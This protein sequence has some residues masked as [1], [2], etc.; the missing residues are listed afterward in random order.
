MKKSE[1]KDLI[2]ECIEEIQTGETTIQD[3]NDLVRSMYNDLN[4]L[5]EKMKKIG[6]VVSKE[7][8][9]STIRKSLIKLGKRIGT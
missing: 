2:R 7:K 3:A 1:L 6:I 5:S 9:I 8:D 4:T